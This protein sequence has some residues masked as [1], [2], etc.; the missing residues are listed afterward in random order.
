MKRA[1]LILA[2]VTLVTSLAA[3]DAGAGW[4]DK[5]KD[6]DKKAAHRYDL[7]PVAS[8]NVGV[9]NRDSR[10]GWQLDDYNIQFV[11]GFHVEGEDGEPADLREGDTVLVM[12]PRYGETILAYR[13]QIQKPEYKSLGGSPTPNVVWSLADPTV[14][15]ANGVIPE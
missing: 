6:N 3:V 13:V 8:F 4:F 1:I 12:G 9:L 15:E 7:F 2:T 11:K 5:D 10:T 14:G